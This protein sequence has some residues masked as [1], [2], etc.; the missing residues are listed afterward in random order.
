MA[1]QK[2][3]TRLG[4]IAPDF[5]AQTT[6]GKIRFHEFIDGKWTILFSHVRCE[7]SIWRRL[8]S[9]RRRML[10]S[11]FPILSSQPACVLPILRA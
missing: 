1:A 10:T 3:G 4:Y 6:Q 9:V 7:S 8:I 11:C 2:T 5:E